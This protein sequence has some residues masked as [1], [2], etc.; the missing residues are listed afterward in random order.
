MEPNPRVPRREFPT[1]LQKPSMTE[2]EKLRFILIMSA[3]VAA[4]AVHRFAPLGPFAH[5]STP[6]AL[7]ATKSNL[8]FRFKF[9]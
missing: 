2:E 6:A 8:P 3:I 5:H 7:N 1:A 9:D 4:L